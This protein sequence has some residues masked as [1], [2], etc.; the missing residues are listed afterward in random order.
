M[1][2]AKHQYFSPNEIPGYKSTKLFNPAQFL[3]GASLK[4]NASTQGGGSSDETAETSHSKRKTATNTHLSQSATSKSNKK[5]VSA[6]LS[7]S[8]SQI[9]VTHFG[10][11]PSSA[12]LSS[13]SSSLTGTYY[14]YLVRNEALMNAHVP[15][16]H[17]HQ[18]SSVTFNS[19]PS[20]NQLTTTTYQSTA[21]DYFNQANIYLT[22]PQRHMSNMQ[23]PISSTPSQLL[24]APSRLE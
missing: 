5:V 13:T 9:K 22:P 21:Y 4:K 3:N 24:A 2:G 23:G 14:D 18:R 10:S 12:S 17:H 16:H 6:Q 19:T 20:L 1:K 15:H 11:A 7:D 8:L